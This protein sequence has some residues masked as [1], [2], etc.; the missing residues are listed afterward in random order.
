MSAEQSPNNDEHPINPK[1]IKE[2]QERN[3]TANAKVK[4]RDGR[5]FCYKIIKRGNFVSVASPL[6]YW[7]INEYDKDPMTKTEEEELILVR[8]ISHLK[9]AEEL[10]KSVSEPDYYD[11]AMING[12]MMKYVGRLL[13]VN[14]AR[15]YYLK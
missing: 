14:L 11:V 13:A 12:I 2:L 4:R 7:A 1:K 3:G 15:S 6:G 8:L 5:L 9:E 10:L